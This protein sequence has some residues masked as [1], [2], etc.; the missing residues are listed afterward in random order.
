M[1][2]ITYLKGRQILDSRGTPTVEV[3][4]SVDNGQI[5]RGSVPSG[6]S[7]GSHEAVELRD[8]NLKEFNGKGVK[9]AVENINSSIK[10][11]VT[12]VRFESIDEF[13]NFLLDLDGTQ[14]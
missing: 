3:D 4:M 9:N 12:N 1:A 5:C 13:D 6:A 2:K 14:N 11:S 10:S 7:T 8:G